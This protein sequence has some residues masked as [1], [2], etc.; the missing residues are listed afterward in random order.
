MPYP[1]SVAVHNAHL[2]L[3]AL[4]AALDR[5]TGSGGYPLAYHVAAIDALRAEFEHAIELVTLAGLVKCN[6]FEHAL[7]IQESR[8]VNAILLEDAE[9]ERL[10]RTP[11]GI[12]FGGAFIAELIASGTLAADESGPALVYFRGD[13]PV[14]AGIAAGERV[15]S[16]WG[17]GH[18]WRHG[19][20]EVP[21]S[22]GDAVARFRRPDRAAVE[23]AFKD[24]HRR[25][26]GRRYAPA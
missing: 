1:P 3:D 17:A 9:R 26:G 10:G 18:L 5:I 14:H 4:R 6:C 25:L 12:T 20:W 11:L 16:R 8:A 13:L 23:A 19:V 22:H 7:D 2:R 15:I 21:S 24:Y